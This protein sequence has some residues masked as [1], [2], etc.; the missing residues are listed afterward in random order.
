[1]Y[2]LVYAIAL[3]PIDAIEKLEKHVNELEKEGWTPQGGP[4]SSSRGCL[5]QAM[6]KKE[7]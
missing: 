4:C 2:K 6:V 7:E 1:M 3:N 5:C